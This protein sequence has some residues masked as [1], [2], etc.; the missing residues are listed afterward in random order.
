MEVELANL[1][2]LPSFVRPL[3]RKK[4]DETTASNSRRG[5]GGEAR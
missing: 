3:D 2:V 4:G 1:S 5:G